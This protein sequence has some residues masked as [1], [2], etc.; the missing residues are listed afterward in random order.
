MNTHSTSISRRGFIATTGAAVAATM[1]PAG[2]ARAQAPAKYRRMNLTDPKAPIESYKKAITAMLALPPSDPRN[3]YRHA[4]VHTLD[5][6]HGNWWFMPWH[7]GYMGYFEQTC[8]ELSG[9]P[10]F[11]FPYWDWTALPRIPEMFFDGILNPNND[12]YVESLEKFKQ[13]Y[14]DPMS[15]LWKSFNDAQIEQLAIRQ[16]GIAPPTPYRSMDVVWSDIAGSPMFF[17]RGSARNLTQQNPGFDEHTLDAVSM[18]K[19]LAGLAPKDYIGFASAASEHHSTFVACHIVEGFPH[20]SVHNNIGGFMQDNLSPTDPL[21]FVHHSNIDRIWD[22][23][24]RKQ[25]AAG[26]PTLPTTDFTRWS[27]EPF[28]FFRDGKGNPVPN[29]KAGDYAEIGDFNY[30]YQPGGSG[31]NAPVKKKS[32]LANKMWAGALAKKLPATQHMASAEVALPQELPTEAIKKEGPTLFA[33]VTLKSGAN[34]DGVDFKV[35]VNAEGDTAKIGPKDSSFAGTFRMFGK[36]ASHADNPVSFLVPITSAV[37]KLSA[38]NQLD[39]AK[40]LKLQVVATRNG[41]PVNV[42]VTELSVGTF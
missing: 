1:L 16:T 14:S 10:T 3:W 9:D 8:R 31:D 11:A 38:A 28:L 2:A 30:D 39:A 21:F 20:N 34:T 35:L 22:M 36:H 25:Q 13:E 29:G 42:E 32:L 5:C 37:S 6:P 27:S 24:T 33:K 41:A 4:L 17:P 26:G 23:W 12:A 18:E 40:D 7:R 15:A 19:L